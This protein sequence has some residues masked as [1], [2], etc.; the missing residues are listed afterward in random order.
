LK[1]PL[2]AGT[3]DL[4]VLFV[5]QKAFWSLVTG[6]RRLPLGWRLASNRCVRITNGSQGM[7]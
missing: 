5:L 6:K 7:A 1:L 4:F 2:D 3:G